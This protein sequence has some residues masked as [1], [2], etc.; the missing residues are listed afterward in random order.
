MNEG[1][2]DDREPY[3]RRLLHQ[4]HPVRFPGSVDSGEADEVLQGL[5]V[6]VKLI[7]DLGYVAL[8]GTEH[9]RE[10]AEFDPAQQQL[11]GAMVLEQGII[12]GGAAADVRVLQA[13]NRETTGHEA[14]DGALFAV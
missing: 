5:L 1:M 4:F 10:G 11:S 9:G 3:L 7:V 8:V 2:P 12:Y 6:R 14:R 13:V